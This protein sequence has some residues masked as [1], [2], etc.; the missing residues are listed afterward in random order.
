[1]RL[2]ESWMEAMKSHA[3]AEAMVCSKFLARRRLRLSHAKVRSTTQRRG[4]TTKPFA[5]SDRLMISTVHL[6]ILVSAAAPLFGFAGRYEPRALEHGQFGRMPIIARLGKGFHG[7]RRGI[8]AKDACNGIEEYRLAVTS[9][10][11]NEGEGV[12]LSG[13]GEAITAPSLEKADHLGIARHGLTEK[14]QP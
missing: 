3:V 9:W 4:S 1:M 14:A 12:F 2:V 5:T 11:M 10:S 6:P 7:C 13:A 8:F